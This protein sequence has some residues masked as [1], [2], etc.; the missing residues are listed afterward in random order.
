MGNAD[1]YSLTPSHHLPWNWLIFLLSFLN[2]FA[3]KNFNEGS[4]RVDCILFAVFLFSGSTISLAMGLLFGGLSALGAYQMSQNPNN[5][6]LLMG[7]QSFPGIILC[8]HP[9]IERRR[10]IVTSALIG[11]A[12]TPNDSCIP[13]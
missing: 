3:M 4:R 12:H 9:A 1:P 7:K 11:W 2:L 10:Y 8:M 13:L 5:Y 6:Q